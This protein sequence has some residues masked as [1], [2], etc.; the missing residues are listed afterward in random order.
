M[1]ARATGAARRSAGGHARGGFGSDFGSDFGFGV[2][3]Y[4]RGRS[5]A[6]GSRRHTSGP[7]PCLADAPV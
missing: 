3:S 1:V 5:P 7:R 4:G 2:G 6:G